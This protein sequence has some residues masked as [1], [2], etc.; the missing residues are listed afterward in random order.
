MTNTALFALIVTISLL[1]TVGL[2]YW[3]RTKG[4]DWFRRSKVVLDKP[5]SSQ[6]KAEKDPVVA[7]VT[8]MYKPVNVGDRTGEKRV[9]ITN[10]GLRVYDVN[11]AGLPLPPQKS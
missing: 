1:V 9:F 5:S 4:M 11:S 6:K 2:Y 10:K 3:M 7:K 8:T